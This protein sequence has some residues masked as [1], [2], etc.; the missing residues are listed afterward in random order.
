M[1]EKKHETIPEV[2]SVRTWKEYLGESML[3]IFSVVLAI[4]MT[5]LINKIHEDSETHEV[6]HELREELIANQQGEELQYKYHLQVLRNIDS[7]LNN[8][9]FL[10]KILD[11]GRVHLSFLA[12]EGVLLE[13][14]NDVSWQVAKEHNIFSKINLETFSL[15]TNIYNHQQRIT[16]TEDEI[17][18]VLLSFESRKAENARITL[19]LM[20]DNYH[21]WAVDRAPSLLKK[22]KKAIDEL[23]KY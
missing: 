18:K 5:E 14:L 20:R 2:I 19:I 15:L 8:E 6:L 12:P 4:I 1:S 22:Y 3:I 7:A 21:A 11:S 9:H 13:D 16:K 17:G 10:K 23:S